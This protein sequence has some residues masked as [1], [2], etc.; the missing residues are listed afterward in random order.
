MNI[1]VGDFAEQLMAEERN[2]SQSTSNKFDSAPTHIPEG[3]AVQAPDISNVEVP[4]SFVASILEGT[5]ASPRQEE[6]TPQVT[7]APQSSNSQ[8]L[9]EEIRDLL[10]GLRSQISEMTSVGM[11]GAGSS[12]KRKRSKDEE[13]DEL[14]EK[15]Q[16]ILSRRKK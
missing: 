10:L 7:E 5:T 1:S 4:T 8:D 16:A 14:E 6:T 12:T 13:T 11:G 15:L 9:L 3:E 2:P